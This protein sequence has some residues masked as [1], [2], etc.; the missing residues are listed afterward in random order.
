MHQDYITCY[1]FYKI[2]AEAIKSS[3]GKNDIK[4][5]LKFF[6]DLAISLNEYLNDD[7]NVDEVDW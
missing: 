5:Q 4:T 7:L 3:E 1:I 6:N 2:G